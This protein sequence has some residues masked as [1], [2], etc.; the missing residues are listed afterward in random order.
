MFFKKAFTKW[1]PAA[2]ALA[3]PCFTANAQN[4]IIGKVID[5]ASLAPEPGAVVQLFEGSDTNENM[6]GY[7]ISDS[8]GVYSISYKS[9]TP[10]TDYIVTISNMG[11][12]M[13]KR[14]FRPSGPVTDL[15]SIGLSDDVQTLNSSKV[16]AARPLIKMEADKIG[17]DVESDPDSKANTVLEMLR[18]VPMV[19]VDG[20]DNITVNGSSSFKVYVDGKPNQ[21]LS[22]NPS[23]IFKV[24]P[25]SAVKNIEVITNPGAKY[26]AEGTGGV[27]NLIT[28]RT[29]TGGSA[30]PDGINGSISAGVDSRGGYDGGLYLNAKKGKF[31]V[32][33]NLYAGMQKQKGS[34]QTSTQ[35]PEGGPDITSGGEVGK[36]TSPYLFGD[37]N[38]SYELDTLNL[39]SAS[40]GLRNWAYRQ[41]ASIFS[42]AL[43]GSSLLYSYSG[44]S[45]AEGG[46]AGMDASFDW[47]HSSSRNKEK[48]ITLSYRFSGDPERSFSE[49][50][51]DKMTG[52]TVN[53]RKVD[54]RNVSQEHTFQ[55]DYTT[56]I[57][58]GQTLSSGLKYIFRNNHSDDEYYLDMGS[59]YVLQSVNDSKYRHHNNIAALYSEYA[60]SLGMFSLKAGLR[61]EYTWLDVEFDDGTGYDGHYDNLVPNLS[62]QYNLG[63]TSNVG[64]TYNMRIS[65]PGISY[66]NPFID[67]SGTTQISYG[68]PDIEPE[69]THNFALKYNFFSPK[70]MLSSGVSYRFGDGGISAYQKYAPDPDDASVMI[71]HSTYGNIVNNK[72]LGFNYFINW[73]PLKD[74][75]VY[76]SAN[77]GYSVISSDML[78]QRN[79]GWSGHFM[80]GGQQT[81]FWDMRL[82]AN[83]F[84]NTRRYSLQGWNSGF[85]G[86]ALSLT[87]SVLQEKLSI[88]VQA[89]SNLKG[90][91]KA[92]FESHTSGAGFTIDSNFAVPIRNIGLE[93]TYNFGKNNF[94]VKKASRT[95]TNDDVVNA[96]NAIQQQNTQTQMQ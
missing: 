28:A 83:L 44:S 60:V 66:L 15:G 80:L 38:A 16:T 65:R 27:L 71:M 89:F 59:G 37:I 32:G 87:K 36:Q 96:Q 13:E 81:I 68:N 22:S 49:S 54:G 34:T 72:T 93:L 48:M 95:I 90:G 40:V 56:P 46:S 41:D 6:K 61:Y 58:K 18:K 24:M 79:N 33:G 67:R 30:V 21:M 10:D 55:A 19:T 5:S 84:A 14:V 77:F 74:T 42:E 85:S 11:R 62:M 92:S 26:D 51:Y 31:T 82:S 29:Q 23:K 53:N 69:K 78:N 94:Q 2:L 47:Q 9:I 86:A 3:L 43:A 25:A 91:R 88:T 17:Y 52:T 1:L 63:Q 35:H 75:R 39:F 76:S 70:I 45:I 7:A 50:I 12:N 64:L 4:K 57:G 73:N 20:Q 8:A